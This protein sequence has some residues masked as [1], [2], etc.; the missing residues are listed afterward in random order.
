VELPRQGFAL[1][2]V[3]GKVQDPRENESDHA[4]TCTARDQ[5]SDKNLI[6]CIY[7]YRQFVSEAVRTLL[8]VSIIS[9]SERKLQS[10]IAAIQLGLKKYFGG[11]D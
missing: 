1:C 3:C 11:E 4:F 9:E 10:F 6:D 7:L 8:P 5:E 2:R